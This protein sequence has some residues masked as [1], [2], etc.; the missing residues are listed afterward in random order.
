MSDQGF[1]ERGREERLLSD[2]GLNHFEDR[3]TV[4]TIPEGKVR[5][6]LHF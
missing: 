4:E 6:I 5:K 2:P 1:G 3:D